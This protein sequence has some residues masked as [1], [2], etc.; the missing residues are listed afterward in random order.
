MLYEVVI[1]GIGLHIIPGYPSVLLDIVALI[2][3]PEI[4]GTVT[5][6]IASVII[7]RQLAKIGVD[8][9]QIPFLFPSGVQCQIVIRH[10]CAIGLLRTGGV[11]VPVEFIAWLT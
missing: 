9:D 8:L 11:Q 10:R 3:F 1:S 2:C 4:G 7:L 6:Q 5:D